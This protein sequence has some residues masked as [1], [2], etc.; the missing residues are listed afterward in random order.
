MQGA[1]TDRWALGPDLSG[2]L[3]LRLLLEVVVVVVVSGGW[4]VHCLTLP[5]IPSPWGQGLLV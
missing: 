1:G 5:P 3:E 4:G 2:V